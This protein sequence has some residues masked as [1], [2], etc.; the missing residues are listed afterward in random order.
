MPVGCDCGSLA[1]PYGI[2]LIVVFA[3][4][5]CLERFMGVTSAE[6]LG[7]NTLYGHKQ[8]YV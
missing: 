6:E 5:M 3:G 1:P 2:I 8:K 7:E 4:H